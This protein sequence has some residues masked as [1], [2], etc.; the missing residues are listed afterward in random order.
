MY[1]GNQNDMHLDWSVFENKG[2]KES[3]IASELLNNKDKNDHRFA[4]S[5]IRGERGREQQI[6][7][8]IEID[9]TSS[10]SETSKLAWSF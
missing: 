7:N 4:L 6:M 3:E 10:L 9:T 2:K 5:A 8:K 1:R